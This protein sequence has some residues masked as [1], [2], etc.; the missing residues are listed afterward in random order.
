VIGDSTPTTIHGRVEGY[1]RHPAPVISPESL[2]QLDEI[3]PRLS[4]HYCRSST[5][6]LCRTPSVVRFKPPFRV[7]LPSGSPTSFRAVQLPRL[8]H[9]SLW[10]FTR[11]AGCCCFFALHQSS[12]RIPDVSPCG[13]TASV[14][15]SFALDL[16]AFLPYLGRLSL[17]FLP[18]S[19]PRQSQT[20]RRLSKFVFSAGGLFI[21]HTPSLQQPA[22]CSLALSSLRHFRTTRTCFLIC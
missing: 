3:F 13:T 20:L 14:E 18:L 2:T 9:P 21:Q 22:A 7:S 6:G 12:F 4:L 11:S 17:R 10:T 8:R 5:P 19:P 1:T 15:T 16:R